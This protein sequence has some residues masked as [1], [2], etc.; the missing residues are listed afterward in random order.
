MAARLLL[1]YAASTN[2]GHALYMLAQTYDP[3]QL[4]A[5]KVQ[6]LRGHRQKAEDL[7]RKQ[8]SKASSS[9]GRSRR[10]ERLVSRGF[11]RG[12]VDRPDN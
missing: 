9:T 4:A 3:A 7:T 1:E 2:N 8:P 10:A 12:A 5:W 6:G 11:V